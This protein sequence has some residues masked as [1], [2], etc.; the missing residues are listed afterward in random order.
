MT[1]SGRGSE[2]IPTGLWV[3]DLAAYERIIAAVGE[4][5]SAGVQRDLLV[6]DLLAAREQ[7]L[8]FIALDSESGAKERK[9]LFSG[10]LDSANTFKERLLDDRHHSYAVTEI[11]SSLNHAPRGAFLY[12]C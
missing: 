12:V 1:K 7:L 5:Y 8:A 11:A 9:E 4:R 6:S 10:I 2:G 3:C